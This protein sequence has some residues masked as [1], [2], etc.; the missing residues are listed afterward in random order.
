MA[1]WIQQRNELLGKAVIA[2]L[3]K[4]NM[5][6]YY[7]ATKEEALAIYNALIEQYKENKL[8]TMVINKYKKYIKQ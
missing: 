3:A 1:T 5:E 6:G 2:N 4:R 7:C 8:L